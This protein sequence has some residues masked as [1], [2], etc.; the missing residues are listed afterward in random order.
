[1]A[2]M[3]YADLCAN[4]PRM[5]HLTPEARAARIELAMEAV[6]ALYPTNALEAK[7]ASSIVTGQAYAEDSFRQADENRADVAVSMRCLAQANALLR[8]MRHML[9][10]YQRM[11][12]EHDKA[13]AEMHPPPWSAPATGSARSLSPCP[14]PRQ[15]MRPNQLRRP[16]LPRR[17]QPQY[18]QRPW[19]RQRR[20]SRPSRRSSSTP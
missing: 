8:D 17:R 20:R 15:P 10:H 5:A 12:A 13:I 1:M 18:R 16:S 9:R 14:R 19:P 11:Q 7:L 4:L 6:T 3:V 2:R